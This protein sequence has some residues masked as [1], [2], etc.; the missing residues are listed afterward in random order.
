MK[1]VLWIA[2]EPNQK[3]LC[4]KINELYPLAGVVLEQRIVKRK[5][6]TSLLSKKF[7]ERLFLPK[8]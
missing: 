1:I 3:A 7:I 8:S 4:S 5:M 2:D 6:N